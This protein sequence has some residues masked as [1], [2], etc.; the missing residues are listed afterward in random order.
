MNG[1]ELARKIA[2]AI[3]IAFVVATCGY[4]VTRVLAFAL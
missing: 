2:I 3:G 1:A 4:L